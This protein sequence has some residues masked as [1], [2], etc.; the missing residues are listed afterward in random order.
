MSVPGTSMPVSTGFPSIDDDP[1]DRRGHINNSARW[2]LLPLFAIGLPAVA[3]LLLPVPAEAGP[4]VVVPMISFALIGLGSGVLVLGKVPRIETPG[5]ALVVALAYVVA[6]PIAIV[7][8][9]MGAQALTAV[10]GLADQAPWVRWGVMGLVATV[11]GLIVFAIAIALA[12][13]GAD[14]EDRTAADDARE[15]SAREVGP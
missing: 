4:E 15:G 11:V 13:P 8:T 2:G 12:T 10:P 5:A 6:C 14:R 1:P 3:Y 9:F 7:G